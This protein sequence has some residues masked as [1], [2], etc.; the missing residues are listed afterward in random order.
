MEVPARKDSSFETDIQ[1]L[2]RLV[3]NLRIERDAHWQDMF[4]ANRYSAWLSAE[5]QALLDRLHERS[6]YITRLEQ[7]LTE[8]EDERVDLETK[9]AHK[10][11]ERFDLEVKLRDKEIERLYLEK[12]LNAKKE[13]E[14]DIAVDP[15]SQSAGRFGFTR[16]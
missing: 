11:M 8:K 10:E 13:Q 6:S 3:E 1:D 14:V 12:E 16:R 4:E 15:P 5:R 9:L 7:M 2:K